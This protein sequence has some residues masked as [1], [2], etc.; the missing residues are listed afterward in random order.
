VCWGPDYKS[1][2]F[3]LRKGVKFQDGTDWNAEA[4]RWNFQMLL[5]TKRLTDGKYVKSFEVVD[6]YTFK[7]YL[8]E[9]NWLRFESYGFMQFISPTAFEKAGGGDMAKS[10]EW[11]RLNAVG[12]GA[13]KISEFQRD[14]VIKYVKNDNYWR[15]GMPYLDGIEI[16]IGVNF[17]NEH[18]GL[19]LGNAKSIFRPKIVHSLD[20]C[21]S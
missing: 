19:P 5:D 13:F 6:N 1:I 2:T 18:F 9:Y 14:T 11:A 15:K 3:T 20:S 10:K 16:H 4:C 7:M 17:V 21:S 8:T 12:T